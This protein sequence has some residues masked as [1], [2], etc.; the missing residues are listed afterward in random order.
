[1]KRNRSNKYM[2]AKPTY[3]HRVPSSKEIRAQVQRSRRWH[4][5]G[6]IWRTL[7]RDLGREIKHT[8]PELQYEWN[9]L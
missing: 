9:S 1:M 5:A 8:F 7:A 2:N 6:L 4:T 3:Q